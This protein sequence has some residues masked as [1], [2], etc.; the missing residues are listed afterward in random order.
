MYS[1]KYKFYTDGA[2]KIVAV[3]S[4]AGKSVRGVA[5]CDPRDD[6]DENSGKALAEARCALKIAE[7]RNARARKEYAK[8]TATL[9]SAQARFDKMCSYLTDS[10][11]EVDRA[12]MTLNVI[13][14]KL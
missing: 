6:F 3:S 4:Y 10:A 8:A 14:Q 7:K 5:K 13:E 11:Q 1:G 12:K 9:K 2:N